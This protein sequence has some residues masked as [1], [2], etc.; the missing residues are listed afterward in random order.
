MNDFLKDA[1]RKDDLVSVRVNAKYVREGDPTDHDGGFAGY[2]VW[3]GETMVCLPPDATVKVLERAEQKCGATEGATGITCQ[4]PRYHPPA[5]D[6]EGTHDPATAGHDGIGYRLTV[7]WPWNQWDRDFAAVGG[8]VPLPEWEREILEQEAARHPVKDAPPLP[9][10]EPRVF[11]ADGPEP[12]ADV[13]AVTDRHHHLP[14]LIRL[15]DGWCWSQDPKQVTGAG[16]SPWAS[17][18][19]SAAAHAQ[20]LDL[21]EVVL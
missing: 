4:L 2:L 9:A 8:E 21:R 11:S 12:P 5:V 16:H 20:N 1:P 10:R 18:W 19:A 13:K 14:Y 6:H 7:R 17:P 15:G 3:I